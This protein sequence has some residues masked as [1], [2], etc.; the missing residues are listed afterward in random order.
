MR[1]QRYKKRAEIKGI[2]FDFTKEDFIN[3]STK[4]CFYCGNEPAEHNPY[5]HK[6]QMHNDTKT[7]ATVYTNGLDRIDSNKGYTKE[8]CVPCCPMCNWMKNSSL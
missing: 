5:K 2:E 8:N 1:Y 6:S 7:R 3:L 4:H